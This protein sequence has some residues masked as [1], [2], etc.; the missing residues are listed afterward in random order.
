M[1]NFAAAAAQSDPIMKQHPFPKGLFRLAVVAAA[2]VATISCDAFRNLRDGGMTAQG[3]PY[4][5]IIV[6]SHDTWNGALGDSLRTVFTAPIPYLAA[7][8]EPHFDVLRINEQ[9]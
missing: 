6:S 7:D 8:T 4:E 2:A 9:G 5:L 1:I 3:R